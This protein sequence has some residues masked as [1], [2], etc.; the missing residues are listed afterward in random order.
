MSAGQILFV[1]DEEPMRIAVKQ[2]LGLAGFD[3]AVLARP[4]AALARL[5]PDFPGILVTDVRM[6]GGMDGLGLLKAAQAKDADLPVILVTGHGD[7]PL[8]VEAMRLGAYDFIEKPFV[9]ERLAEAVGR[10]AEK[11]RLVMENRRLRAMGAGD[12]MARRLIGPSRAMER[13]RAEIQALAGLPL[14]VVIFGD[15]GCGKELAAR[16]LH[17]Y[18]PR[19]PKPFVAVNCAAIPET[20]FESEFFGHEAGAFTGA[21]Q[22]RAGK[23]EH[24]D[25][26]T[27]F[28]DEV[29]SMPLAL[30]AKLLRVLQEQCVEPLGGN[31]SLPVDIRVITAAKADLQDE[32]RSGRFREDLYYRLHVAEIRLP[33]LAERQDDIV[34]LFEAFAARA[35]GAHG[36]TPPELSQGDS[37]ALLAHGWPGN[38]REL[39][40]EAERFALGLGLRLGRP[41]DPP[42]DGESLQASVAAFEKRR[43]EEAFRAA[44]GDVALVMARLDLPRRTLNEKMARY[45]IDRRHF[46]E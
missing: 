10:A 13:V 37:G 11:R 14:N 28:L 3:V 25:G 42:G 7:I 45:G 44:R 1:D 21:A 29:E 33:P 5:S 34:P 18:G 31:R 38:V 26:G 39:R 40:N 35:A 23:I 46:L 2:W 17:D 16:C 41:P 22:R 8:A 12:D 36:R 15:T 43:I 32:V 27:L 9:P 30:Q 4:E 24:A 20:M 19:A 6:P